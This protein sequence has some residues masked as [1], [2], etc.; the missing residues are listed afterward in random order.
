MHDAAQLLRETGTFGAQLNFSCPTAIGVRFLN[1]LPAV[2]GLPE[3]QRLPGPLRLRAAVDWGWV[4]G[5]WLK[6]D[7]DRFAVEQRDK[8]KRRL[9]AALTSGRSGNPP[10]VG[11]EFSA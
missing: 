6:S 9:F 8:P 3:L 11:D 2:D 5:L 4:P 10:D 1:W 7:H